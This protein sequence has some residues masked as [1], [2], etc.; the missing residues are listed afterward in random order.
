MFGIELVTQREPYIV[1]V[2]AD[3]Q[4]RITAINSSAFI[5]EPSGWIEIDRGFGDKYHHAQGNYFDK[6]IVD[7]R[8]IWRYK[9]VDGKPVVDTT[10]C[11]GCGICKQLCK[12]DALQEG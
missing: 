3:E 6:A 4:N 8:G 9:L 10:L 1:Y 2:K 11:T 7:T 5:S 12:F